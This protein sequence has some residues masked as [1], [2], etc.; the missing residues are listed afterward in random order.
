M[1]IAELRKRARRMIA[2]SIDGTDLITVE[3][4]G[5]PDDVI[6]TRED[7]KYLHWKLALLLDLPCEQESVYCE[8]HVGAHAER[9][10][11]THPHYVGPH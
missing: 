11:C 6:L 1:S 9:A 7:A 4:G 8:T 5:Q 3:I 2:D 10:D